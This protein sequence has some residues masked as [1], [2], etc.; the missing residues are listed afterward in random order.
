MVQLATYCEY[1][2]KA[3]ELEFGERI[4]EITNDF[5]AKIDDLRIKNETMLQQKAEQVQFF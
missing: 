4:K 1:Q 5:Q 3:K 2:L